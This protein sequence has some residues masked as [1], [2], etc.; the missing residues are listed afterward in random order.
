MKQHQNIKKIN[1]E[2]KKLGILSI[3]ASSEDISLDVAK[4]AMDIVQ[5]D[6]LDFDEIEKSIK[7]HSPKK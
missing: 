1:E 4:F 5:N 7:Q 6:V 3:R 2:L